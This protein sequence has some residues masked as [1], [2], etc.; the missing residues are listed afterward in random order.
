MR[1]LEVALRLPASSTPQ[2]SLLRRLTS[3]PSRKAPVRPLGLVL[4]GG[5][6]Q[7][8][9]E[10]R[11]VLA[12][13][14]SLA[15][16]LGVQDHV[17]PVT[18]HMLLRLTVRSVSQ[19][20]ACNC[21]PACAA[22]QCAHSLALQLQRLSQH[23]QVRPV[24]TSQ[25]ADSGQ[26]LQVVFL[27]SFTDE[28]RG[29]LLQACRAVVYT[30]ANEHFGIVPLEAMAAG[31]PV[32]AANSGGPLETVKHQSTGLLCEPQPE[33]FARAM[34]ALTVRCC[35]PVSFSQ[36]SDSCSQSVSVLVQDA[37]AASAMGEQARQHVEDSFSRQAFGSKLETIML[38]LV[39]GT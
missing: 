15:R 36:R 5:Y 3:S 39:H 30:P 13:L 35:L 12:E 14:Q 7:R 16:D 21:L 19:H 25:S 8:L 23:L 32:I 9:L 27:P 37:S 1:A 28:Q 6:D 31:R 18:V 26:H 34:M 38:Q 17:S 4:A 2:V 22:R 11:E 10:N 20:Q 33:A 24:S 29:E